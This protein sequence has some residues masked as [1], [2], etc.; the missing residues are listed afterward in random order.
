[1]FDLDG[2]SKKI[3][4]NAFK[5]QDGELLMERPKV[6]DR[7]KEYSGARWMGGNDYFYLMRLSRD[8]KRQDL[9]RVDINADSTKTIVAERMNT[10]VETRNPRFLPNGDFLWWSERNGWANIYLYGADGTC[11]KNLTEGSFHVEDVLG[12]GKRLLRGERLRRESGGEPLPDAQLPRTAFRRTHGAAGHG[13]H[14]R[15]GYLLG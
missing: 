4:W 2:N 8:L 15:A 14:G 1:M 11:K 5:D 7:Y 3:A 9:C 6:A 13:R 12:V 10:Y